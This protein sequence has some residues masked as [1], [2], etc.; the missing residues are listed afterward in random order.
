MLAKKTNKRKPTNRKRRSKA[1]KKATNRNVT[2]AIYGLVF[3]NLILIISGLNN[4]FTSGTVPTGT[5]QNPD[6]EPLKVQVLN[7]C[8]ETGL[9]NELAKQLRYFNYTLLEPANADH[10]GYQNT[11]IVDLADRPQDVE[12]LRNRIG[13]PKDDVYRLTEDSEADVQIIIGKDYNTL[14]IFNNPLP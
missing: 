4:I 2:F 14:N 9:A 11:L 12:E 8:G 13:I 1:S 3:F 7:G 5:I 10:F 6:M